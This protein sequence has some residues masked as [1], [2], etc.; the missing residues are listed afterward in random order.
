M[1]IERLEEATSPFFE[2]QAI[3]LPANRHIGR[4]RD[5]RLVT[6]ILG[7][8][9]KCLLP[10]DG[11]RRRSPNHGTT[12]R[13]DSPA[14]VLRIVGFDI[15]SFDG[16]KINQVAQRRA[17]VSELRA[18]RS[19][20]HLRVNRMVEILNRRFATMIGKPLQGNADLLGAPDADAG[21]RHRLE[22]IVAHHRR[23]P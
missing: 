1:G 17:R 15:P 4:L 8:G 21:G 20:P 9:R 7:N 16:L 19:L 13:G 23:L 11:R 5:Q 3:Q 22:T 2:L 14:W 12:F 18:G 10:S 6:R